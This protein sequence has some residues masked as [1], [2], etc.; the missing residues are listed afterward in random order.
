MTDQGDLVHVEIFGERYTLRG[1]GG[2]D[3]AYT[4]RVA[5]YVDE[6]IHEVAGGTA[7][8][9][10]KVAV[11]ASLNIADAFLK[12]EERVK[13]EE[14]AAAVQVQTLEAELDGVIKRKPSP[15]GPKK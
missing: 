7:V 9:S 6:Q 11:L 13:K 3:S 1:L 14:T 15:G 4:R 8:L 2:E 5:Q 12:L 10:V